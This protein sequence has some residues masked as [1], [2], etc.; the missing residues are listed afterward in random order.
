[1]QKDSKVDICLDIYYLLRSLR[2][3]F[4]EVHEG[5]LEGFG[6]HGTILKRFIFKMDR[7]DISK[8]LLLVE[9]LQVDIS[10]DI[11]YLLRSLRLGKPLESIYYQELHTKLI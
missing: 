1:M 4:V 2:S 9:A 6:R 3:G 7:V 8:Y 10:L 11:N 5:V